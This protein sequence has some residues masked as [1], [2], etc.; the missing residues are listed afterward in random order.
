[1]MPAESRESTLDFRPIDS[2]P[3]RP[4]PVQRPSGVV[5]PAQVF[6]A[7]RSKV[8]R[9][10]VVLA[11]ERAVLRG[12]VAPGQRL[13]ENEI[14]RQMGISKAPVREALRRLEQLGLVV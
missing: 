5:E 3:E 7:P 2:Q 9:D 10:D 11:I 12:D 13:L 14:A 8:L 1:M 4:R 6:D